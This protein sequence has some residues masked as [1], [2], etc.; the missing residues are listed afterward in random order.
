M[1]RFGAA[2]VLALATVAACSGVDRVDVQWSDLTVSDDRRSI[3][4][5][6]YY[7]PF[8][9]RAPDGV[10]IDVGD[11]EIVVWSWLTDASDADGGCA[12]ECGTV[13]QVAEL[14]DP[15]PELPLVQRGR[16]HLGCGG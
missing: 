1:L 16:A 12:A 13:T 3:E 5:T 15:L 14:D 10:G 4:I 9:A 8:C 11:D 7:G 6:S 2:P